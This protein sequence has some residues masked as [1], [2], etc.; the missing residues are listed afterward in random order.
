MHLWKEQLITQPKSA[1]SSFVVVN[2]AKLF[3]VLTVKSLP[4]DARCTLVL[5]NELVVAWPGGFYLSNQ[6]QIQD[7]R[8]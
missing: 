4:E 6:W 3:G 2:I 8:E 1:R 7:F 5:T